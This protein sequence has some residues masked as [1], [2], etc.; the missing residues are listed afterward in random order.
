MEIF[1]NPFFSVGF[2]RNLFFS[3]LVVLKIF[4][5]ATTSQV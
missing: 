4:R 1:H 5:S 2:F 3:S